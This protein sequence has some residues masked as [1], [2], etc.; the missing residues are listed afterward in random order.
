MTGED[1]ESDEIRLSLLRTCR[2]IYNECEDMLGK[3]STL[4]LES[5]LHYGI[6]K[7]QAGI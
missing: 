3:C 4:D 2:Q 5:L 1:Y 6:Y 7:L